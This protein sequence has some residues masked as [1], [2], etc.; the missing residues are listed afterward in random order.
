MSKFIKLTSF[1]P[2]GTLYVLRK[3]IIYIARSQPD[4]REYTELHMRCLKD[5]HCLRVCETP[6]EIMAMLEGETI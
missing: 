4:E 5:G 6:E 2:L 1:E 3:E